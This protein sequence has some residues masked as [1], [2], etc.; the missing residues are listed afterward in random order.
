MSIL[1]ER[2]SNQRDGWIFRG[3]DGQ[4]RGM[5]GYFRGINSQVRGMNGYFRG[6]DVQSEGWM[7]I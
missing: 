4:V 7:D 3:M 6:K 2:M 5:D 1:E